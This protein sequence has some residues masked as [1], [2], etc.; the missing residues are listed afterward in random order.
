[1]AIIAISSCDDNTEQLGYSLTN[2]VDQFDML[3][4]TF[5][6]SSRS[7]I[8]DSVLS[9]SAYSYLGRIKD[10]ETGSLITSDYMTQFTIL[11]NESG[12][13]FPDEETILGREDGLAIAD[14]CVVNLIVNSWQGDS[15]AAMK[16][17][18][19]EL[20]T[21]VEETTSYYTNF[22]PQ[23]KGYVRTNGLVQNKVYSIV[24]LQL[25]DSVRNARKS[26]SYMDYISIPLNKPY[27]DKNGVTYNNYGTYI[28]RNYYTHPEYFKNSYAFAHHL[29]PGFYFKM[30]DG[31]GLM[32]QINTTQLI[33]YYHFEMDGTVYMGSKTFNGTEE[34]LQTTHIINDKQTIEQLAS[35]N[36]CTY[37][38]TPAG[39]YTEVTLPVSDIKQGH[40][41]DS[42]TLA[43]I[44][45][46]RM[47]DRNSYSDLILEEPTN[48]LMI[49]RD[50]LY[51]FFEN[52][53]LP[54]N[55]TSYTA[56]YS[57][58]Y[59][60]YTFNNISGMINYMYNAKANGGA[61]FVEKHP[62][63]NKVVLIP[64][65]V[66]TTSTSSYYTTTTSITG[67][68][69]EMGITSV[70]LVG[71]SDNTHAPLKISVVYNK[72]N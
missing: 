27:T 50:S 25:S 36:S 24:D 69:N 9:R 71:G 3:P 32:S 23:E 70:R 47:N 31:L 67:V 42:I 54:D 66:T 65:S 10:P 59:N 57:S 17:T 21:P 15:L 26:G 29:C 20:G 22:D 53:N 55:I 56:T 45:F 37:L 12:I 18:A 30:T 44:V 6:V 35:D 4:D 46:N 16:M 11:E 14:S 41:N 7:I 13:M 2:S 1:M 19:Y 61:D 62:N 43:K 5:S 8:A 64:V 52:D 33:I 28:L 51:S 39:I 34:V 68:S 72:N 38:K 49:E 48:L 63:W 40:E 60:T 58:T